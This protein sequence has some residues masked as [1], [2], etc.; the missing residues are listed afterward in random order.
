MLMCPEDQKK[1]IMGTKT[2][3]SSRL[4]HK[5]IILGA[6]FSRCLGKKEEALLSAD[7]S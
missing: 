7:L 5:D 3:V 2:P 6:M 4:T 1:A